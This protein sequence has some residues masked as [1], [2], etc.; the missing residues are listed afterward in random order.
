MGCTRTV[1]LPRVKRKLGPLLGLLLPLHGARAELW[2]GARILDPGK[3]SVGLY[4]QLMLGPSGYRVTGQVAHGLST[5]WQIQGRAS[6]GSDQ[7][8]YNL[9]ATF[10]FLHRKRF[11]VAL[12]GGYTFQIR[13]YADAGLILSH[14][15]GNIQGY[16]GA[17][18]RF[19]LQNGLPIQTS[20]IPGLS[21]RLSDQIRLYAEA[22]L[23]LGNARTGISSG[24]RYYF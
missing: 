13:S 22:N 14:Y 2:Q 15:F 7:P 17:I 5:S 8:A 4:P 9:Y 19:P 6:Y 20:V 1:G 23:G 10:S 12:I 24:V 3:F 21:Y 11:D 16:A 18:V